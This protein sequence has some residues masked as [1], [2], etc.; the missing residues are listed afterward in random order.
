MPEACTYSCDP[1]W[2]AGAVY[3][4]E[5]FGGHAGGQAGILAGRL[6]HSGLMVSLATAWFL[7]KPSSGSIPAKPQAGLAALGREGSSQDLCGDG[8]HSPCPSPAG[9]GHAG[10]WAA[11]LLYSGGKNRETPGGF[12]IFKCDSHRGIS[13]P[14][15]GLLAC[16]FLKKTASSWFCQAKRKLLASLRTSLP[17]LGSFTPHQSSINT[18]PAQLV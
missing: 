4:G 10:T 15:I 11:L 2:V 18:K 1:C 3:S 9:P 6:E 8:L 13:I 12:L 16:L 17:R 7:V 14:F 5:F